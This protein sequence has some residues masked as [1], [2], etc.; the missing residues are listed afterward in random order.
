MRPAIAWVCVAM[1]SMSL[2]VQSPGPAAPA[3]STTRSAGPDSPVGTASSV[4]DIE[5]LFDRARNAP[6]AAERADAFS[7]LA[8]LATGDEPDAWNRTGECLINAW[9][10]RQQTGPGAVLLR[11]AAERGHVGAMRNFGIYLDLAPSGIAREFESSQAWL[12]KARDA[13]DA[14]AAR[15]LKENERLPLL[16]A[17]LTPPWENH[18]VP[19]VAKRYPEVRGDELLKVMMQDYLACRAEIARLQPR[20]ELIRKSKD[21]GT[22]SGQEYEVARDL[23][24]AERRVDRIEKAVA[25]LDPERLK[26]VVRM[27]AMAGAPGVPLLRELTGEAA[28]ATRPV[29]A[30]KPVRPAPPRP[31]N[32]PPDAPWP[33]P[34]GR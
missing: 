25:T 2:S 8:A 33:P 13:G 10:T 31:P 15:R 5:T 17:Q 30:T 11:R 16:A 4:P 34:A 27:M 23:G 19:A 26:R 18:F 3:P 7:A 32:Y 20:L 12:A 24:A 22:S 29:P 21:R 9:G 1:S 14:E 28:P 6:T